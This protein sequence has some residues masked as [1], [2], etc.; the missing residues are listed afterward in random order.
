MLDDAGHVGSR[1]DG[2]TA[3]VVVAQSGQLLQDGGALVLECREELLELSR[4]VGSP[5][6]AIA[7]STS[8]TILPVVIAEMVPPSVL[9]FSPEM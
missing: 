8:S 5:A 6:A 7:A 2:A 3:G 9:R 1:A 4:H